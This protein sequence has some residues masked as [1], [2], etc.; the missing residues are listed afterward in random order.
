MRTFIAIDLPQEIKTSLAKLQDQ[1]KQSYADVK[2]VKPDNIHLTLKFLGEVDETKLE[3]VIQET[4]AVAKNNPG[5][6]IQIESLGSF[7]KIDFPRVVWVGVKQGSA[8]TKKIAKEL[9]SSLEKI[10]FA[11]EDRPFSSHITIGRT[12]SSK[13]QRTLSDELKKLEDK[14]TAGEFMAEKITLYKSTL[15]PQGPTYEALREISLQ[16]T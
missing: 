2:W 13:N 8:E 6:K 15:S 11:K 14:F 7:P 1:L 4:E 9:E 5:F 16:T 12:R 10:G 3:S